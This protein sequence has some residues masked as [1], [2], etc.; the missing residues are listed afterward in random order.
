MSFTK[1]RETF[2]DLVSVDRSGLYRYRS[3]LLLETLLVPQG[4]SIVRSRRETI[5]P[6]P[7]PANIL[8]SSSSP[9]ANCRVGMFSKPKRAGFFQISPLGSYRSSERPPLVSRRWKY[10]RRSRCA[11]SRTRSKSSKAASGV[12]YGAMKFPLAV[13][14][15]SSV[16]DVSLLIAA[17]PVTIP[18]KRPGSKEV[19]RF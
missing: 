3:G 1:D 10:R 13:T 19:P 17:P 16:H 15:T 2:S 11:V 6:Y 7:F 18:S 4:R 12:R 14:P 9:F 5:G 8:S